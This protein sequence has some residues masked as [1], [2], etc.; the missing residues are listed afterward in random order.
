MHLLPVDS[1]PTP[2]SPDEVEGF[3]RFLAALRGITLLTAAEELD[4]A[5]RIEMGDTEAR[6]RLIEANLR[7]VVSIAKRHRGRGLPLPD[8]VQDGAL[9]L[10]R[11][12]DRY[13]WRAG[14]RIQWVA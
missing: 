12:A 7:L 2:D 10:I 4:L 13:D 5:R 8:L 1:P 6:E 9:G 11:A 3:D 14:C